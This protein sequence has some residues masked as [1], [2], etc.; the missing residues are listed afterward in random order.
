MVSDV[1]CLCS[2]VVPSG[3]ALLILSGDKNGDGSFKARQIEGIACVKHL[4]D[5]L[6]VSK[7]D[8]PIEF[9]L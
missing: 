6:M 2:K 8:F 3:Q 7:K 4:D 1:C 9:Q 5:G